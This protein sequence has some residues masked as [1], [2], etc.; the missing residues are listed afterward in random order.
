[1]SSGFEGSLDETLRS[2]DGCDAAFESDLL[3][4]GE[5]RRGV[6]DRKRDLHVRIAPCV[7]PINRR[8]P[9]TRDLGLAVRRAPRAGT[10]AHLCDRDASSSELALCHRVDDEARDEHVGTLSCRRRP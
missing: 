6:P 2:F 8:L 4:S 3:Q 1:V 5:L 9:G 10:L 7:G